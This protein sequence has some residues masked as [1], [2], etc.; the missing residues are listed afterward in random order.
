MDRWQA[1]TDWRARRPTEAERNWA[2]YLHNYPSRGAES[3]VEHAQDLLSRQGWASYKARYERLRRTVFLV[4]GRRPPV[5]ETISYS[6]GSTLILINDGIVEH[7]ETVATILMAGGRF[8]D[9]GRVVEEPALSPDAVTGLLRRAN[10]QWVVRER[11][12]KVD[13]LEI[14]LGPI[15]RIVATNTFRAATVFTVLHEF[16]HAANGHALAHHPQTQEVEADQWAAHAL[17]STAVAALTQPDYLLGAAFLSIRAL[18]SRESMGKADLHGYPPSAQ[19]FSTLINVVRGYFPSEFV[20]YMK[21]KSA[22]SHDMRMQRAEH[23]VGADIAYPPSL[24]EQCASLIV[25]QLHAVTRTETTLDSA[26]REINA[27]L[28]RVP[29]PVIHGTAEICARIFTP[30]ACVGE[31]QDQ[32]LRVANLFG[33]IAPQLPQTA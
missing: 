21:T 28:A 27:V 12:E 23:D 6:D 7:L 33:E 11:R 9:D 18:A 10:E 15:A 26:I 3:K 4:V 5:P 25:S 17:F 13:T 2:D 22:F 32:C 1:L 19:R 20:F 16:G 29:A 30:A 14:P 24:P 8:I 31:F